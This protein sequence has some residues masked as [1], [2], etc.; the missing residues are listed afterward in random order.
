M[1]A[2]L[3]K[4]VLITPVQFSSCTVNQALAQAYVKSPSWRNNIAVRS[5]VEFIKKVMAGPPES[6][7]QAALTIHDSVATRRPYLTSIFC[8][9]CTFF[10]ITNLSKILVQYHTVC[11]RHYWLQYHA[12]LHRDSR[13]HND[14]LGLNGLIG[15]DNYCCVNPVSNYSTM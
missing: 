4:H 2:P 9:Q 15:F 5:V 14:K 10:L 7:K 3:G 8:L 11:R 1:N 12:D 6:K 13:I